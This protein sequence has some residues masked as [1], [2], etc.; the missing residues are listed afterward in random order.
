MLFKLEKGFIRY[1]FPQFPVPFHS[2]SEDSEYFQCL[3]LYLCFWLHVFISFHF[4][5]SFS[6]LIF[7]FLLNLELLPLP[8]FLATLWPMR[9]PSWQCCTN[10]VS[11]AN[12]VAKSGRIFFFLVYLLWRFIYPVGGEAERERERILSR[13]T[14]SAQSLTQDSI[15]Q[16]VRSWPELKLD[17]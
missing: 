14:P 6:F 5:F 12:F 2:G 13:L 1:E 8:S 17:A 16:I 7:I 11:F 4:R 3:S 15:P 9:S 10:F